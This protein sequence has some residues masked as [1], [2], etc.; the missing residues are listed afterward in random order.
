MSEINRVATLLSLDEDDAA[1][2]RGERR[3]TRTPRERK[4]ATGRDKRISFR[5]REEFTVDLAA[6]AKKLKCNG[7]RAME[8][9]VAECCE[10]NGITVTSG[11]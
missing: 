9:A 7:T 10:R 5:V 4:R 8:R 2:V 3:G 11:D 6:L 1:R